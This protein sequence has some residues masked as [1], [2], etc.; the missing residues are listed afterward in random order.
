[1]SGRTIRAVV[2]GLA[3]GLATS[4]LA[5][6]PGAPIVVGSGFAVGTSSTPGLVTVDTSS[7]MA[8]HDVYVFGGINESYVIPAAYPSGSG[9]CG[10]GN[11]V[12]RPYLYDAGGA[13][14]NSSTLLGVLAHG[15]TLTKSVNVN[16][17]IDLD[18]LPDGMYQLLWHDQ[19]D[20]LR[21]CGAAGMWVEI[22]AST[23]SDPC[24]SD[25]SVLSASLQG[26]LQG[27]DWYVSVNDLGAS[28]PPGAD[29]IVR[30]TD[31]SGGLVAYSERG[32][33]DGSDPFARPFV[34][35]DIPLAPDT[36]T[37]QLA[38][39]CNA[40]ET[41]VDQ[42]LGTFTTELEDGCAQS[43]SLG[44]VGPAG[45]QNPCD[46]DWALAWSA[47]GTVLPPGA[48]TVTLTRAGDPSFSTARSTPHGTLGNPIPDLAPFGS[49]PESDAY[50]AT[51]T[52]DCEA[53]GNGNPIEVAS[54][55]FTIDCASGSGGDTFRSELSVGLAFDSCIAESPSAFPLTF[56]FELT[57]LP[58]GRVYSSLEL[59]PVFE[60]GSPRYPE[61]WV[62]PNNADPPAAS[63]GERYTAPG[64]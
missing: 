28:L 44:G 22:G 58:G 36:Y 51:L 56:S 5:Q 42:A 49:L 27:G 11:S 10:S 23:P 41:P 29:A 48:V 45:G 50:T 39:R 54:S 16:V 33:A 53:D 30:V 38:W 8:S 21:A 18:S 55:S 32:T 61:L 14:V 43:F 2:L 13:R 34:D 57:P 63:P 59:V 3:V 47:G 62:G 6:T 20:P 15:G 46:G 35:F 17:L 1:M 12:I 37:I 9:P 7:L 24:A 26:D 40:A 60:D 64:P 4:A 19:N 31:S 25:Y 52:W